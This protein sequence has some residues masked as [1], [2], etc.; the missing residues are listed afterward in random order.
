MKKFS[1]RLLIVAVVCVL[2]ATAV[3]A[4]S[5]CDRLFA[6]GVKLQQTMTVSSQRRAISNFQ[7]AKACYDSK[8]KKDLCDEQIK[9]CRN[10]IR[11]LTPTPKPR[12]KNGEV[13][14]KPEQ[15]KKVAEK[16]Q[17][18]DVQLSLA[19]PYVKFKGKGGEFKKVKVICNYAD[20]KVT[21]MPSWVNCS[22]NEDSEVVIEVEKNPSNKEERSGVIKIEC[23]DEEITLTVIQE[24]FK[25]FGII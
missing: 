1:I 20:W 24:K 25:R 18:R 21:E 9:A 5:A 16:Q 15:E 4:Q 23:G 7:K 13:E 2:S 6:N 10:I 3:Q 8:A 14:S 19:E 12:T 17:K 11:K 22:K